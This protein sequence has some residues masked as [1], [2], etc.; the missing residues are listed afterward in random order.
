MLKHYGV[1]LDELAPNSDNDKKA[2]FKD[3]GEKDEFGNLIK[4]EIELDTDPMYKIRDT[5]YEIDDIGIP[6]DKKQTKLTDK[7]YSD[8]KRKVNE[9]KK[10]DFVRNLPEMAS[11]IQM[12]ASTAGLASVKRLP[13]PSVAS[14]LK[15]L[16]RE[17]RK[18]SETGMDPSTKNLALKQIESGRRSAMNTV[19]GRGGTT[20]E[21]AAGITDLTIKAH[22]AQ[23]SLAVAD[24]EIRLRNKAPYFDA[25]KTI[26][27]RKDEIGREKRTINEKK[28]AMYAA[29]L[30]AGISNMIGAKQFKDHLD[31][32]KNLKT[33]PSITLS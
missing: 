12:M 4:S 30:Q 6:L 14:E 31:Y 22:E 1:S 13:D 29:L 26:S 3:G 7:A 15:T 18:L 23:E 24:T 21:I 28:E 11:A 27:G 16:A 19:V 9:R 10:F 17:T 2:G 25:L 32:L 20:S 5:G 8:I 33:Q